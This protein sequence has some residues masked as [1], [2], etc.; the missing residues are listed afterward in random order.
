MKKQTI[1]GMD[2]DV[3]EDGD[4]LHADIK[5]QRNDAARFVYSKYLEVWKTIKKFLEPILD[6]LYVSG[7][8]REYNIYDKILE[9]IEDAISKVGLNLTEVKEG[10]DVRPEHV[11][12]L[13]EP[14]PK[15]STPI[16]FAVQLVQGMT[17]MKYK[18]YIEGLDRA[19]QCVSTYEEVY[20]RHL[21][22]IQ[23][24][25]WNAILDMVANC[26]FTLRIIRE[27]ADA[28]RELTMMAI[29]FANMITEVPEEIAEKLA[30]CIETGEGCEEALEELKRW[31][32]ESLPDNALRFV[33]MASGY[34][35]AEFI[36]VIL[37]RIKAIAGIMAGILRAKEIGEGAKE[38][39]PEKAVPEIAREVSQSITSTSAQLL[40]LQ[41]AVLHEGEYAGNEFYTL[42]SVYCLGMVYF[43]PPLGT[44]DKYVSAPVDC[45]RAINTAA[46]FGVSEI[47]KYRNEICGANSVYVIYSAGTEARPN[48]IFPTA[49]VTVSYTRNGQYGAI[50]VKIYAFSPLGFSNFNFCIRLRNGVQACM[51]VPPSAGKLVVAYLLV[52]TAG[53]VIAGGLNSPAP[54]VLP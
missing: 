30:R 54:Q 9:K 48:D 38:M 31:I 8:I 21:D 18:N 28:V 35:L 16:V 52:D 37:P 41:Q 42:T 23:A 44:N 14:F 36:T 33:E 27:D 22:L 53:N 51:V 50:Y 49:I 29:K 24:G 46:G 20:V 39:H 15:L 5:N 10:D 25:E 12:E 11:N 43:G 32:A 47:I 40:A 7:F 3:I 26:C 17:F 1:C 4:I 13:Y 45:I 6:N 19:L 34:A 2:F